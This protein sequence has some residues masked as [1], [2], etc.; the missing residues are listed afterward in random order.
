MKKLVVGLT[1]AIFV[2]LPIAQAGESKSSD[3]ATCSEKTKTSAKS[4]CADSTSCCQKDNKV[5]KKTVSPD[6]KGAMFLVKR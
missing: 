2:L 1:I 6:Q 4:A 5:A 3:K